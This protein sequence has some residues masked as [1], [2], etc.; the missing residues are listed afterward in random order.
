MNFYKSI[1]EVISDVTT[2]DKE[3]VYVIISTLSV[4]VIFYL[5]KIIGRKIIQKLTS[6][7]R[8]FVSNHAYQVV[9]NILEVLILII[10]WD[11][12]IKGLMTLISVISAA[13]TIA[14]RD[15]IL[16]FFCGIYIKFKKPFKVEDRIQIGDIKGDVM[17]TSTF[18]FEILEVSTKEDNG[19]STGIVIH[20]PNSSIISGPVKNI[21][22]GFKYI[23]DE[24]IVKIEIDCDLANNKK[25]IYKIVNSLDT[26][27]NIPRKMKN[28]IDDVVNEDIAADAGDVTN[29]GEDSVV[30]DQADQ[31]AKLKS[32]L[33]QILKDEFGMDKNNMSN[34]SIGG[35]SN[36]SV[37]NVGGAKLNNSK[38]V[39]KPSS[40][41]GITVNKAIK[42]IMKDKGVTQEQF[43]KLL[44]N[45]TGQRYVSN[46]LRSENMNINNVITFCELLNYEVVLQ[47]KK[48]GKR[49]D[50][51]YVLC[52]GE[53]YSRRSGVKFLKKNNK[54]GE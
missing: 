24:M 38:Q 50:G 2:I 43:G 40:S 7:R 27:K 13:M 22:K 17:S 49:K 39:S 31:D 53:M 16:N 52:K 26:V 42:S 3:Y 15:F 51:E 45:P 5:L 25:E 54:V 19:Q 30:D 23:W 37:S 34:S 20:Y 18:S 47:P 1:C 8:E 33:L 4:L 9:L 29:A 11:E 46:T 10:I 21:N 32:M 12:Y 48:P 35:M 6:G 44:D 41:S 36:S 28:Q 14:L